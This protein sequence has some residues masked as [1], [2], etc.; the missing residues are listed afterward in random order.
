MLA[1]LFAVGAM[2][3]TP[4]LYFIGANDDGAALVA[5]TTIKRNGNMVEF[6]AIAVFDAP[7]FS[8]DMTRYT[9]HVV[10]Y[11]Q[12][13]CASKAMRT[14]RTF[15]YNMDGERVE[16]WTGAGWTTAQPRDVSSDVIEFV[17]SPAIDVRK[18]KPISNLRSFIEGVQEQARRR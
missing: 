16:S 12:A 2:T 3:F 15:A 7:V 1:A 5:Q 8:P 6:V 13:N 10:Q 17:C 14:M 18:Y 9:S 4:G 11:R